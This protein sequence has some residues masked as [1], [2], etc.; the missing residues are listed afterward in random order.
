MWDILCLLPGAWYTL[1]RAAVLP[2]LV[3]KPCERGFLFARIEWCMMIRRI[4]GRSLDMGAAGLAVVGLVA[5]EILG[6]N[7]GR[8]STRKSR[9]SSSSYSSS[10]QSRRKRRGKQQRVKEAQKL[11][12]KHDPQ[13]Q[14]W[15]EEAKKKERAV[16]LQEQA[17]VLAKVVKEQFDRTMSALLPSF[18]TP[19]QFLPVR[20]GSKLTLGAEERDEDNMICWE[21]P[22]HRWIE[23][24]LLHKVSCGLN[25]VT[26]EEFIQTLGETTT[27]WSTDYGGNIHC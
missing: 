2:R 23:A 9:S 25:G 1:C 21:G 20:L 18:T 26:K 15:K 3:A 7:R 12:E 19:P 24:E 14:Q 27:P 17:E 10:S 11:L 16:E 5:A 13:Y 8:S 6:G 22:Q 4:R